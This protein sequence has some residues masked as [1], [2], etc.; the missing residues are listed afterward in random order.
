MNNRKKGPPEHSVLELGHLKRKSEKRSQK[1]TLPTNATA[2]HKL[3]I[4]VR[5]RL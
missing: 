4:T 3:M 2:Y 5:K 1:L